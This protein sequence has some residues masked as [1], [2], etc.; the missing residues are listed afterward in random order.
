M[1]R[2]LQKSYVLSSN[3]LNRKLNVFERQLQQEHLTYMIT[4]NCKNNYNY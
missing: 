4:I 3:S 1:I 2:A